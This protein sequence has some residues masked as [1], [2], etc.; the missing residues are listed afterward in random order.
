M[1]VEQIEKAYFIWLHKYYG[2]A[3]TDRDVD[4]FL[5][6]EIIPFVL[7][8]SW[9]KRARNALFV[10]TG[11]AAERMEKTRSAYSK[12]EKSEAEGSISLKSLAQ[13]AQAL[14][15]EFVYAIRPKKNLRFSKLIWQVL[16]KASI[17]D[18][19]VTSRPKIKKIE[20]LASIAKK[21]MYEAE[22]RR[23]QGWTERLPKS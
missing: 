1:E 3:L 16:L 18:Y 2:H 13:A 11:S 20:A 8:D 6:D 21:K 17:N 5:S 14:D 22:F 19:W 23:K 7:G 12:L 4:P 10:S 15:C 9:L